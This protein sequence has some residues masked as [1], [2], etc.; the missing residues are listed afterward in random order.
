MADLK[1][2]RKKLENRLTELET[3]AKTIDSEL[4]VPGDQ[5]TEERAIELETEEVLEGLGNAAVAEIEQIR[6]ALNRM[7]MGTYGICLVCGDDI[8]DRRLDAVPHTPRCINCAG[9]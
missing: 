3:E 5:D 9:N 4:R 6:N 8:D 7:D 1:K 2:L